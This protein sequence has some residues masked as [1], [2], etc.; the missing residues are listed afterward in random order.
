MK[1][2][3]LTVIFKHS[4]CFRSQ[5]VVSVIEVTPVCF[6][7][8]EGVYHTLCH[9]VLILESILRLSKQPRKADWLDFS[10]S[11]DTIASLQTGNDM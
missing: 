8:S 7:A 11:C 9:T 5:Y 2:S 4:K 3:V 1:I 10:L 6:I